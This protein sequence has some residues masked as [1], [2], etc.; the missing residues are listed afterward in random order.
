MIM[1]MI[2]MV[3]IMIM[4]MMMTMMSMT[5]DSSEVVDNCHWMLT[6]EIG[7]AAVTQKLLE[8]IG[9]CLEVLSGVS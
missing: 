6:D 4:I 2:M 7:I 3:M 1:I 5:G 9:L 8:L